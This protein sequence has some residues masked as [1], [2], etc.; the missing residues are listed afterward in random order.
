MRM[1]HFP[2]VKRQRALEAVIDR[3]VDSVFSVVGQLESVSS[4]T[5]TDISSSSLGATSLPSWS[6]TLILIL[7]GPCSIFENLILAAMAQE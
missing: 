3:Q 6:I 4:G 1:R 2:D 7:W 5:L